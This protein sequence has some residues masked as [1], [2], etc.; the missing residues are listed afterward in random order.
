MT[1]IS[2]VKSNLSKE[3]ASLKTHGLRKTW[4]QIKAFVRKYPVI[5][6]TYKAIKGAVIGAIPEAADVISEAEMFAKKIDKL[7]QDD[8]FNEASKK[9]FQSLEDVITEI[10][11]GGIS[12]KKKK[13]P[14]TLTNRFLE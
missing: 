3:W 13:T 10:G 11:S 14:N 5:E 2:D 4:N 9:A 6:S 7:V 1:F 12:G 8:R